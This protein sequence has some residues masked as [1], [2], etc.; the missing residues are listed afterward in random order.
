M[1]YPDQ[2]GEQLHDV[3]TSPITS[4]ADLIARLTDQTDK[5]ADLATIVSALSGSSNGQ[6]VD[7]T[8]YATKVLL[9]TGLAGRA[10]RAANLSDLADVAVARES[11]QLGSAALQAASAFA[12]AVHGH[13]IG[14]VTG[15][16]TALAA[17]AAIGRRAVADA[18]ATIL[19]TDAYVA[20]STL[21]A[22][23]TLTLPAASAYPQGQ[24]LYVADE[25][26]ACSATNLITIA[27]AGTDTIAGQA[28]ITIGSAFQK[29]VL[30]SNGTNLWAV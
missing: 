20:L 4:P 17:K 27:A 16:L 8:P 2:I 15:L 25:S 28:S 29:V 14:D 9:N 7:L 18:A 26:G 24:P 30:H 10:S 12:A 23:R 13:A 6:P 3:V 22:P 21:T 5:L 1:P 11:L 19:A